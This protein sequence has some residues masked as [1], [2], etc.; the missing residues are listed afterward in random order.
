MDLL[1]SFPREEGSDTLR[2]H[3]GGITIA[4]SLLLVMLLWQISH[5]KTNTP[6]EVNSPTGESPD[7]GGL[8]S[9]YR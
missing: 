1:A 6:I 3:I 2:L 4:R 9:S 5:T 7:H 8:P